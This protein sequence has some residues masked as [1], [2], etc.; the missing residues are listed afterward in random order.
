[1]LSIIVPVYNSEKYIQ[2]CLNSIVCQNLSNIEIVLVDDGSTDDSARIIDNAAKHDNRITVIHKNNGGQ[3]SARYEGVKCARGDIIGFVDSDDYIEP[4]MFECMLRV[5]NENDADIVSSGIIRE[6]DDGRSVEVYDHFTP[7]IYNQ[8]TRTI[9]PS[10]LHDYLYKEFGI[11]CNVVNKLFRRDML[12]EILDQIPREIIYGED[13]AIIYGYMMKSENIYIMDK[14]YYHYCIRNDSMCAT[15]D[16]RLLHSNFQLYSYLYD[17]FMD[18]DLQGTLLRQ[19]KQYMIMIEQHSTAVLYDIHPSLLNYWEFLV[20]DEVL[21]S[22]FAIYGAGGCGQAFFRYIEQQGKQRNV[23]AWIDRDYMSLREEASYPLLSIEDGLK[24]D[25]DCIL[26]AIK[27]K[28]IQQDIKKSLIKEYNV[29]PEKVVYVE[30]K[31][32]SHF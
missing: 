28:A 20:P 9:Y 17:V 23:V 6:Y 27:D 5:M 15:R 16:K 14:A 4:Q 1:M 3:L 7:G 2:R 19:L 31:E 29:N 30:A 8:L 18:S 22:Q 10:M 21:D 12:L 13:A 32:Y 24:E 25:Y 11:H 26:I